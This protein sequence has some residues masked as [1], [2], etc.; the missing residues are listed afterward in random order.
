MIA[1]GAALSGLRFQRRN[2]QNDQDVD[3][4]AG[5]GAAGAIV[6]TLAVIIDIL[7]IVWALVMARRCSKSLSVGL[8]VLNY[9]AAFFFS[10]VYIIIAYL[11]GC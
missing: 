10:I 3:A 9:I 6:V 7:L 8:Q 11:V 2:L 1:T 5:I 4:T